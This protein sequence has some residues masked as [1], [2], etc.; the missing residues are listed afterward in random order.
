MITDRIDVP[1]TIEN[2]AYKLT[3]TENEK[4]DPDAGLIEQ[5]P[6]AAAGPLRPGPDRSL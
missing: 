2:P 1:T 4:I 3:G 6:H 5:D